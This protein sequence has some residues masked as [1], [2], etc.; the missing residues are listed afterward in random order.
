MGLGWT[1]LLRISIAREWTGGRRSS[2]PEHSHPGSASFYVLKGRVGH[3]SQHGTHYVDAATAMNSHG[4]D[5]PMQVFTAT[6]TDVELFAMFVVDVMRPF[7]SPATAGL[8]LLA[9]CYSA[10]NDNEGPILLRGR[11]QFVMRCILE[12]YK[13]KP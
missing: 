4:A 9:S 8:S 7:S 1:A 10:M 3:E 6:E 12:S 11:G 13:V 5:T 2:S